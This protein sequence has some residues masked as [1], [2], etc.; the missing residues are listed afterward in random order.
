MGEE[1]IIR[2]SGSLHKHS[3][4]LILR[5]IGHENLRLVH[6]HDVQRIVQN[7]LSSWLEK[8][9]IELKKAVSSMAFNISA[10]RLLGNVA[11]KISMELWQQYDDISQ[12]LQ[13]FPLNIVGTAYYKSLQGRKNAMMILSQ[14]LEERKNAERREIIDF[15]DLIISELKK[16]NPMLT[17]NYALNLLFV[18]LFF[19]SDTMS[20]ALTAAVKFLSDNP[21]ALQKL[22]DEHQKIRTARADPEAKITWE[23]YKT[24]KFTSHVV[25]ETLRLA[26]IAPVLFRKVKKDVHIN[27]YTVPEGW[28]LM[29]CLEASHLHPTT[30]EDPTVFNP[31]RWENI[32][33][34]GRGYKD[35]VAFGSGLRLCVGADLAKLQIAIFLHLLVT[36]HTIWVEVL[37]QCRPCKTTNCN[38]PPLAGYK[39]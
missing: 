23:E 9:S 1:N 20:N 38:L 34:P 4:N 28:I 36:K 30:Y 15:L 2:S 7:S 17:E 22:A 12:G 11:S 10:N 21:K 31:S 39:T 24:M 25:L 3:R 37:C 16:E 14:L 32:T 19:S 26:N 18:Q 13:A 33:K 35:F 5:V 6:L 27:G 8:P 29:P